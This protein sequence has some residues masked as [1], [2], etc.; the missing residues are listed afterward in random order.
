MENFTASLP[1]MMYRALDVV[2]PRFRIIFREAGLTEQQWR[3]LR[4][5]WERNDLLSRELAELTLIPPPS[6]VGIIDRLENRNLVSRRRDGID[7]RSVFVRITE[8]GQALK[9]QVTPRVD[10]VYFELQRSVDPEVW[11]QLQHGLEC[12][13]RMDETKI[14]RV[15]NA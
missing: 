3:I 8:D 9:E 14:D 5:L 4:V 1:M 2:M 12:I 13:C 11:K 10:A 6:L 7:R 15:A